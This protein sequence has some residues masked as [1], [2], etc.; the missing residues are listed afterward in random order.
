MSVTLDD[1]QAVQ[2]QVILLKKENMELKD[3]VEAA[4]K[5]SSMSGPQIV[6]NLKSDN[7]QLRVTINQ[8]M[9]EKEK[10]VEK[11]RFIS[12]IQ[13][14]QHQNLYE[15]ETIPDVQTMPQH[16]RPV[17]QEVISLMD[18]V[19]QQILRRSFLDTQVNE[20]SKKTKT[21]GRDGEKLQA[22]IAELREKQKEEMASLEAS[23]ATLQSLEA[24]TAKLR[25][26]LSE[27]TSQR[28]THFTQDDLKILQKKTVSLEE[29]IKV[30]KADNKKVIDELNAKIDQHNRDIEDATAAKTVI[31]KKLQ[32]KI[33][34]LQ[35]E[36]NK[37]RGI[38]VRPGKSG[39]LQNATQLFMESKKLIES[40]AEKQQNNWELEERVAFTRNS[41][42]MMAKEIV[43]CMYGKNVDV[44]N[45]E[46]HK[47]SLEM[48]S[49]I[50]KMEMEIKRNNNK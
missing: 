1:F 32:Q 8:L 44:V 25:G 15:A 41:T 6:E 38:V 42:K 5:R 11:M 39:T 14:L 45:N 22:K 18:D 24:E 30:K 19:K 29:E 2:E 49:K 31:N 48:I 43:K 33:S 40:I 46:M 4:K 35:S 27:V 50:M 37:R 3:Q 12:I 20:L 10:M 28:T 16:V 9:K 26:S 36:I 17:A 7:L 21:L 23:R 34:A 47:K 13:F